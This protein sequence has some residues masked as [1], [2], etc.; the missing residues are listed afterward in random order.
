MDGDRNKAG[1][2]SAQL[3]GAHGHQPASFIHS[4]QVLEG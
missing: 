3:E 1:N 4:V 2:N